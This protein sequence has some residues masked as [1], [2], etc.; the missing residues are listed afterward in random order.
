MKTRVFHL[1]ILDNKKAEIRLVHVFFE[2]TRMTPCFAL[3]SCNRNLGLYVCFA[4]T[5]S[6]FHFSA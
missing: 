3:P 5:S 4:D 2:A 1:I 6:F